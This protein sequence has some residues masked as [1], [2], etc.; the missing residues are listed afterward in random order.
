L[1][2]WCTYYGGSNYDIGNSI[3]TDATG[4]IYATGNT[5]STSGIA[6]I[7]AYKTTYSAGIFN[8][9]TD[10]FVV[11]FNSSGLRQWG[12]YYGDTALEYGQGIT[13]DRTGNVYF[14][15]RTASGS[16][17]ATPSAYQPVYA[18]DTD[19]FIV[20]FNSS[21]VRIWGTYYGG[22]GADYGM[23]IA[24]DSNANPLLT[25]FTNSTSGIAT[26]GAYQTAFGGGYWDAFVAKFDS[27]GGLRRW[28]TYYGG[29]LWDEGHGI[30]SD[31]VTNVW[32]TGFT[33]SAT[34]IVPNGDGSAF[35]SVYGGNQDAFMVKFDQGGNRLWGTYYGGTGWEEGNG[36]AID[37]RRNAVFIGS[38]SSTSSIATIGA[39]RTIFAGG[40]GGGISDAFLVKF[41][42]N[43][44]RQWATYYGG[45]GN[46]YG[47]GIAKDT[48][49]NTYVTGYTSSTTGMAT[50]GAFQTSLAGNFDAYIAAFS[51]SGSLPVKLISFDAKLQNEKQVLLSWQTVSEIN[52]DYFEVERSNNDEMWETVRRVKGSGNSNSIK[53]YQLIDDLSNADVSYLSMTNTIYYRLKQV[54]FDGVYSFSNVRI[55]SLND[56]N[57]GWNMYPNPSSDLVIIDLSFAQ[58]CTVHVSDIQG[59]QCKEV[60]YN[61]SHIIL[62]TQ[63]LNPGI[64]FISITGES[65]KFHQT[66]KLIVVR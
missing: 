58:N 2:Q 7:G 16:G 27:S 42:T 21:G 1:Q 8:F 33:Q 46:D 51:N 57:A 53:N 23:G 62:Q 13:T 45:T 3:A 37:A 24:T 66:Q 56:D 34:G 60:Q 26:T 22:S 29:P 52:N 61:G 44:V 32:V 36:V 20:K 48:I 64:Y 54:D 50:S 40:I 30:V 19:A 17:I 47:Q 59:R 35:Q 5:Y 43:G 65:G 6:T 38:T 41:D 14:T 10:A 31:S 49:G 55:V 9:Y 4:S 18:G 12:T 15:G 63:S 39:Y 28:G 25:G 11:K